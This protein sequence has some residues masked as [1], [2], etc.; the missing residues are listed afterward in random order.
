[1][2][3]KSWISRMGGGVCV[4]FANTSPQV[5]PGAKT[6]TGIVAAS[7]SRRIGRSLRLPRFS[8]SADLVVISSRFFRIYRASHIANASAPCLTRV[9]KLPAGL[10]AGS[11][12]R[13]IRSALQRLRFS[14][15]ADLTV[16]FSRF[17]EIY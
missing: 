3:D 2:R 15:S 5:S 4:S 6:P 13:R 16:I 17:L 11:P 9:K 10:V 7:L 1:M 12:R 14:A 8:A